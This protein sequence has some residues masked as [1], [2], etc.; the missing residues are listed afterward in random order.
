MKGFTHRRYHCSKLRLNQRQE[1]VRIFAPQIVDRIRDA[2]VTLFN[3]SFERRIGGT[4]IDAHQ[5]EVA[6]VR[7]RTVDD[8][9]LFFVVGPVV[10]CVSDMMIDSGDEG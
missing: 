4:V 2:P 3:D 8:Q 10:R 7:A 5:R 9:R 1:R 6:R